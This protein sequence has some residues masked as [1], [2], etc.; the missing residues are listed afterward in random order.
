MTQNHKNSPIM[1]SIESLVDP[2]LREWLPEA[3]T[4]HVKVGGRWLNVFASINNYKDHLAKISGSKA[5][6]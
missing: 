1:D 3:K 5:A 4:V 6:S 2:T